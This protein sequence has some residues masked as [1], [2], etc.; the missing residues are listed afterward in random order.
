VSLLS[1]RLLQRIGRARLGVRTAHANAGVGNRRSNAR[2][3]GVEFAD[4]RPYQP[5]DDIRYLDRHV[6]A[7]LGNHMIREFTVES[8]LQVLVLVDASASMQVGT[9]TKADRARELAAT[10]AYVGLVG[11]D[12]VQVAAIEAHGIRW[13]PRRSGV[14]R[15][16][17]IFRFLESI[18][19]GG[20]ADAAQQ[21][22]GI[23]KRLKP[24]TLLVWVSD[25]QFDG[26]A[27]IVSTW[28][29]QGH[30]LMALP[31]FA[32]EERSPTLLGTDMV[33]LTDAETGENAGIALSD[34]VVKKY[35]AALKTWEADCRNAVVGA[36]GRWLPSQSDDD[37]EDLVLRVW[38]LQGVIA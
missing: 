30:E 21:L 24:G 28:K 4:H 10:I 7:R 13:H 25:F 34:E 29:A 23:A 38:R 3:A 18:R 5:G 12:S 19:F 11:G 8:A 37:L 27:E 32:P 16:G 26:F 2:G 17:D 33:R 35:L 9:P 1:P 6:Y 36:G 31:V 20:S 15:A 22:R 14:R